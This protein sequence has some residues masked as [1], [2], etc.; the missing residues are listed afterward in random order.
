MAANRICSKS[1]EVGTFKIL[2]QLSERHPFTGPADFEQSQR[3]LAFASLPDLESEIL[4]GRL[5]RFEV[6]PLLAGLEISARTVLSSLA[7][8]LV[9]RRVSFVRLKLGGKLLRLCCSPR[10]ITRAMSSTE[11]SGGTASRA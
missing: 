9:H 5:G 1:D 7:T 6:P 8:T 3:N 10:G 2:G 4:A 11:F